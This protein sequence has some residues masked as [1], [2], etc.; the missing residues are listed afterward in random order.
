M[1]EVY[2]SL[3]EQSIFD[4]AI[5]KYGDMEGVAWLLEDNPTLINEEGIIPTGAL[6]LIRKGV[7]I[8]T[9]VKNTLEIEIPV[10]EGIIAES[11]V[12]ID[13][14]NNFIFDNKGEYPTANL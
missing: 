10:S 4:V 3:P 1:K 7:A 8:N 14:N 6:Y 9:D 13:D 11:V 5:Q 12:I 2:N